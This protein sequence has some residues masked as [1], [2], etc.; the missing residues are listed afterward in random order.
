MFRNPVPAKHATLDLPTS[1]PRVRITAGAGTASQKTWNLRRPVTLIGSRRPAHIVLH[2]KDIS[3]A[4]CVIVN[5]GTEVLLKDLY[6]RGGTQRNDKHVDFTLLEDGDVIQVGDSQI[7]IAIQTDHTS[8]NDIRTDVGYVDPFMLAKPC[9]LALAHTDQAWVLNDA[10]TLVGSHELAPIR[11]EHEQM[12]R[13]H[14]LLFRFDGRLAIFSLAGQDSVRVNGQPTQ[15]CTLMEGDRL[16]M[17]LL[18][19]HFG[20]ASAASTHPEG[21]SASPADALEEDSAKSAEALN[22]VQAGQEDE[23]EVLQGN[24]ADSWTTLN[25]WQAQLREDAGALTEHEA[26]L[27]K[28]DLEQDARDA[29][30]RGQLHDVQRLQEQLADRERNLF[31]KENRLSLQKEEIESAWISFRRVEARMKERSE[32]LSR[33][34]H[35]FARR[36]SKLQAAQD[37]LEE[38]APFNAPSGLGETPPQSIDAKIVSSD[39]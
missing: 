18:T 15:V 10:V 37:A 35:V 12:A 33:R 25:R 23:L 13:R 29:A 19:L 30:L 11:L 24:I 39:A 17:G 1:A 28:R 36:W 32:E 22:Q 9:R 14:A 38:Q 31:D 16:R 7:R 5:T 27:E 21:A 6:T 2:D 8:L 20:H 3:P 26:D 34:E 4:H